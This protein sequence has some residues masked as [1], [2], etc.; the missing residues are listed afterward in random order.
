MM[1]KINLILVTL[2]GFF[3]FAF[4]PA[5]TSP[6]AE[7]SPPPATATTAPTSTIS[8]TNTP[9]PAT[10]TTIPPTDTS[11]PAPEPAGSIIPGD[12]TTLGDDFT[13]YQDETVGILFCYPAGWIVD[14]DYLDTAGYL[15]V[16]APEA[17]EPAVTPITFLLI[18]P[19]QSVTSMSSSAP[20]AEEAL[21]VAAIAT[22]R[23]F[24]DYEIVGEVNSDSLHDQN[25]ASMEVQAT[26]TFNLGMSILGF[27][28]GDAIT[29]LLMGIQNGPAAAA[30]I[31]WMG[32][33]EAHRETVM[34]I[35][36]SIVSGLPASLSTP[37]TP[38]P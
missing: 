28:E 17:L 27:Q 11:T 26:M 10:A 32:Q 19:H 13:E 3:L 36:D 33:D 6:T 15:M 23:N 25:R 35:M 22:R 9:R 18:Y 4:N 24:P 31:S 16:L 2:T 14:N 34:L 21:M 29:G 20:T 38:L 12:C 30:A 7:P 1:N 8:A 37:T 5:T